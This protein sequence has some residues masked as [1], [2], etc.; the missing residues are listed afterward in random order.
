MGVYVFKCLHGPY[1]KVGHHLV[2][3]R[4]PHAWY[5]VAG[6][7]FYSCKHPESLDGKLGVEHL[8]LMRW[9]PNLNRVHE[10]AI[11]RACNERIG[12]F[13][14]EST[15]AS[16]IKMCE[17]QYGAENCEITLKQKARAIAWG[18]RRAMRAA[19]KRGVTKL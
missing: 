10:R 16:I 3:P 1:V 5:R 9:Y 12:E 14:P 6:R 13:H 18:R 15:L 8:E 7:G 11:H 17:E 2:A 19:R 4:R